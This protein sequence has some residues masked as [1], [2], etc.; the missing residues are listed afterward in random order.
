MELN[1]KKIKSM[2][3]N[4]SKK[5]QFTTDVNL[6]GQKVEIIEQAKLLGLI[7]TRQI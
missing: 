1:V 4:F 5:F 2:V 6:K 3:F 7:L